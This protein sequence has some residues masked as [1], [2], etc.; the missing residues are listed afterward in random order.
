MFKK[1]IFFTYITHFLMLKL[2]RLK[3]EM[4]LWVTASG[5]ATLGPAHRSL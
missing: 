1:N 4:V 3:Q 2:T 5:P